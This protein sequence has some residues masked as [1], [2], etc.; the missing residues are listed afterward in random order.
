MARNAYIGA[1]IP[2]LE[3]ARFLRGRGTYVGDLHPVRTSAAAGV[4]SV[5]RLKL[6]LATG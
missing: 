6:R 4:K 5:P 2:R 1:G 3:D